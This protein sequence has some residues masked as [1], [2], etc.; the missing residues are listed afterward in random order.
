MKTTLKVAE[1]ASFLYALLCFGSFCINSVYYSVFGV[2]ITAYMSFTEILLLFLAQPILYVPVILSILFLSFFSANWDNPISINRLY[3]KIAVRDD[4][5]LVFNVVCVLF[6]VKI[7]YDIPLNSVISYTLLFAFVFDAFI[8]GFYNGMLL[9]GMGLGNRIG[10]KLNNHLSHNGFKRF[11]QIIRS[12]GPVNSLPR[13]M[14]L[15]I[16]SF[17]KRAFTREPKRSNKQNRQSL[18]LKGGWY[19]SFIRNYQ[20]SESSVRRLRWIYNNPF[21]FYFVFIYLFAIV[22]MSAA[23]YSLA[24]ELKKGTIEPKKAVSFDCDSEYKIDKN[25]DILIGESNQYIFLFTREDESVR[26]YNRAELRNLVFNVNY[27]DRM[28]LKSRFNKGIQEIKNLD[29]ENSTSEP[30]I[31][32]AEYDL[33]QVDSADV[34]INY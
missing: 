20:F 15:G 33:S 6:L 23:N 28:L 32:N 31:L 11:V 34:N 19:R 2:D 24:I 22:I 8:P 30:N 1:L 16:K 18:L 12:W 9:F 17:F 21:L 29:S 13:K 10:D 27:P 7:W 14:W 4:W 25:S 3:D 26:V 5:V